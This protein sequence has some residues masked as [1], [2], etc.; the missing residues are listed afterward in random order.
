MNK[1]NPSVI[2]FSIAGILYFFSVLF[3]NEILILVTKPIIIPSIMFFYFTETKGKV[4]FWFVFSLFLFF[5]GDIL[6]LINLDGYYLLG[7]LFYLSPYSIVLIFIIKDFIKLVRTKSVDKTD[8][9][10]LIILFFLTYLLVS[11]M[12]V[13]NPDSEIEFFY[14]LLFGIEL[15]LMGVFVTLLYLHKPNKENFF[16]II[17]VSLFIVSDISFILHKNV[18]GL[19]VFKITNIVTQLTSYYFYTKYLIEKRNF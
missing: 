17:A 5:V 18:H 13:L 11:M 19:L 15:V 7:L 8:L 12:N 10:F 3:N 16:L 14:F 1:I 9:S 6:Y 2:L 4:N